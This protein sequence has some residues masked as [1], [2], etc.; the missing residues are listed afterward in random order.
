[1]TSAAL[2]ESKTTDYFGGVGHHVLRKLPAGARRVLEIG[3]GNGETGAA[4]KSAQPD[5]RWTGLELEPAAAERARARLDHVVVGNVETLPLGELDGP[6]DAVIASEVLEHLVDPWAAVARLSAQ[7]APGGVFIASSPNI[8]SRWIVQALVRGR[9]DYEESGL[10]DR[11]HLRWFTPRTY[12]AIFTQAGL[13][14][15]SVEPVTPLHTKAR[16]INKLTGGRFEHLFVKQTLVV[17]RRRLP[18]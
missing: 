4:A 6:F 16:L 18:A 8:A 7:L 10:M 17:A 12:A 3:C 14:I 11:T 5:L 2:Y 9:F 13:E 15:V 1:M